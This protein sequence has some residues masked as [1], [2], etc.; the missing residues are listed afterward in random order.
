MDAVRCCCS[1]QN[2]NM[3]CPR[4]SQKVRTPSS[5]LTAQAKVIL[6]VGLSRTHFSR[7]YTLIST[8]TL[9]ASSGPLASINR[10]R[11]S[12]SLLLN[13]GA[14]PHLDAD[15]AHP[16]HSR[17]LIHGCVA[18][19]VTFESLL[20]VQHRR[21]AAYIGKKCRQGTGLAS[22]A[23]SSTLD[24]PELW[25]VVATSIGQVNGNTK[26]SGCELMRLV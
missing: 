7:P 4:L 8:R 9:P 22:P 26:M 18:A 23:Q 16:A 6:G 25:H 5:G 19:C 21:G 11:F 13:R 12:L 10:R 1:K 24:S 15:G 14:L 17:H 3:R 2:S 20:R